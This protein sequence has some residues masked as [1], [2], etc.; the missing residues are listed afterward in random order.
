MIV[1]LNDDVTAVLNNLGL[2]EKPFDQEE[3]IRLL[4]NP[5]NQAWVTVYAHHSYSE[6]KPSVFACFADRKLRESIL[7]GDDWIKHAG[8]FQPGFWIGNGETHYTTGKDDGYDFI[9]AELYFHPYEQAQIH[10]NQEFVLLFELYRGNDGCYYSVDECGEKE[11]VVDIK[12]DTVRVRTKY[13]LRYIAAKQCLFVYFVDSRFASSERYPMHAELIG[14]NEEIGDNYHFK[15]WFQATSDNGYLLSMLYSRSFIEPGPQDSCNLWPYER[16]E[17]FYP[18][19]IIGENPDGSSVEFTC[20]P[21]KLGT[22][23]D[24]EITAPHYLTPVYFK[25]V[26]LDK[27][28]NN[29]LFTVTD[30]RL[31]CGSQWGVEIDNVDPDRVMVFLGDLGRDLP[32]SERQHFLSFQISPVDHHIS[33]EV[34]LN[35]FM[36]M[37]TDPSGPVSMLLRAREAL[38]KAWQEQFGSAFYR[39]FHKNDSDVLRQIRIPSGYGEAEFDSVVMALSKAFVDYIDESN[40]KEHDE[41]GSINKLDAFLRNKNLTID[42]GPLRDVQSIRSNGAA[43][44]K[45]SNYDKLQNK[46]VS[47]DHRADALDLINNLTSLLNEIVE[48]LKRL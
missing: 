21:D 41:K 4:K 27:Y 5:L 11:K 38:D 1:M 18:N 6:N 19:F 10:I 2:S 7:Q 14:D 8:S 25:P 23:F 16:E 3:I 36:N 37:F 26:V 15:R 30:R 45:G 39:D 48:K 17:E 35:D 28:R 31:T 22:Y 46:I 29:P 24:K 12:S 13:I 33:E 9:V 47:E 34:F 20:D 32:E 42:L 44:G 40:F 43:H